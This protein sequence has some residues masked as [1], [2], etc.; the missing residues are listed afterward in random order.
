MQNEAIQKYLIDSYNRIAFTH[1]YIFGYVEGG[2]VYGAKVA[3]GRKIL[4]YISCL[5]CASSKNGGTIQLKYKPNRHQISV[6]IES[7]EEIRAICSENFLEN[8]F[9]STKFN[10]GQIFE[11][12]VAETF[13][14]Y[15]VENK[16][17]KF[18]DCGDIIVDT[19]HYQV[20]YLKATFT[21]E[22]T[23]RNFGI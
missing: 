22:R 16:S 15:Q 19:I 12:L 2:M 9:R 10:R 4:P 3:D 7:A 11:K 6:I 14:G 20:K 23:L 8:E 21:D 13:G 1:S 5:D 18:T 17:A